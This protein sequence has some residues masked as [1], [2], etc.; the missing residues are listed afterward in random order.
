MSLDIDLTRK[1]WT[2]YDNKETHEES[3]DVVY[4]GRTT[5]NLAKMAA[6]AGIYEA[7]W[8]PE[9]IGASIASDIT[10][11]V[12]RGLIDLIARPEHY[13]KYNSENGWGMYDDL[14]QFVSEYLVALKE[15]PNAEILI[16]R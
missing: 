2:S 4:S 5:H 7:L 8:K 15:Y 12:E 3:V 13:K 11:I 6:A 14:V 10:A 1:K 9:N 16:S